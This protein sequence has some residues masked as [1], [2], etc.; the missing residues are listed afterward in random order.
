MR[1]INNYKN[2]SNVMQNNY[3]HKTST[4]SHFTKKTYINY[5]KTKHP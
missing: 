4:L 3:G 1:M 2:H 5:Q